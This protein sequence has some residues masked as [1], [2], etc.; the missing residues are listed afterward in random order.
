MLRIG[1]GVR[2]AVI[3][4]RG[5]NMILRRKA[6]GTV[7]KFRNVLLAGTA[8]AGAALLPSVAQ[9]QTWQGVGSG[10]YSYCVII[11]RRLCLAAFAP[12]QGHRGKVLIIA[13]INRTRMVAMEFGTWRSGRKGGSPRSITVG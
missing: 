11:F 5:G 2:G 6:I 7:A 9:A 1:A 3:F 13:L 4:C 10:N 8:L 12:Q